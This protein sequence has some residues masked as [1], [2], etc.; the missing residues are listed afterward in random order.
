MASISARKRKRVVVTIS[1]KLK[2]HQLVKSRRTFQSIVDEY[3][4][5]KSTV[6]N[7]VK[8]EEKLHDFQKETEDGD[9]IKKRKTMKK[10][11]LLALDK[12]VYLWFVQQ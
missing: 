5:G 6:H 4:F 2:I 8:N 1:D 10:A 3:D 7:N 12:A 9:C 11:D